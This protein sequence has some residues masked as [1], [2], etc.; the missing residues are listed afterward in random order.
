MEEMEL[1]EEDVR[2]SLPGEL[3]VRRSLRLTNISNTR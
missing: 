1:K 3:T 2:F